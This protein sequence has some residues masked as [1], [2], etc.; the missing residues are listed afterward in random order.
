MLAIRCTNTATVSESALTEA[1]ATMPIVDGYGFAEVIS[2][3]VRSVE[4]S[5]I[6]NNKAF[7]A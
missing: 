2:Q 7:T 3:T 5:R 6:H 1:A 4:Y